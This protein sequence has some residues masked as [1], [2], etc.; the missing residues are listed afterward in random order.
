VG[1]DVGGTSIKSGLVDDRGGIHG[2]HQVSTPLGASVDALIEAII[3]SGREIIRAA[4][5]SGLEVAGVGL[6]VPNFSVGPTWTQTHCNNLP[7]LEGVELRPRMLEP[8]GPSIAC[9][10]DTNAAAR[11]E[12]LF[13]HASSYRRVIVIVIGTGISCGILVDG[14]LLRH[15]FGTTGDTGHI[16]VAPNS[17]RRCSGGCRGCLESVASAPAIRQAA[18]EAST[19]G[20]S[21]AL[22]ARLATLGDLDAEAVSLEATRGDPAAMRI[23]D[24]AGWALGVALTSLMHV[25]CP[26]AIL[27]GGGVSAAGAALIEPARRV[28]AASAAPYFRK[29]LRTL[30]LAALGSDAGMIGAASLILYPPESSSEPNYGSIGARVPPDVDLDGL[31]HI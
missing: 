21:P 19:Q 10:L 4:G 11:A 12:Y 15:T 7:G 27:V 26:E 8:F 25:Y 23:L 29:Y 20:E 14:A 5:E 16:I 28:I 9:D 31:G 18:L 2:R 1:I 6:G 3:N 13:G 30:Q 17:T 22:A 24:E